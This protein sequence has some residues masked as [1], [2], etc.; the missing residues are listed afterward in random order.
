M[1]LNR[2]EQQPAEHGIFDHDPHRA[3]VL[4]RNKVE[5]AGFEP[6]IDQDF[7]NITAMRSQLVG[8]SYGIEHVPA[9]AVDRRDPGV[10]LRVQQVGGLSPVD[11]RHAQ[12]MGGQRQRLGQTDHAC[13]QYDDIALPRINCHGDAFPSLNMGYS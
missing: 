2:L 8:Q 9:G 12:S 11:D 5:S 13:T 1:G 3:F 4:S 6:V 10:I 7:C